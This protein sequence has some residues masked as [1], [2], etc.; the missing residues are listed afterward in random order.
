MGFP[1]NLLISVLNSFIFKLC[2]LISTFKT[3]KF[4]LNTVLATSYFSHV[5][6][7]FEFNYKYFSSPFFKDFFYMLPRVH[8]SRTCFSLLS[9]ILK[10]FFPLTTL[11]MICLICCLCGHEPALPRPR[12]RLRGVHRSWLQPPARCSDG[13]CSLSLNRLER[14]FLFLAAMSE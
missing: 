13:V 3:I 10:I 4:P 9:L 14:R 11:L 12:L 5:M 7:T 2:S 8:T 1:P 6:F